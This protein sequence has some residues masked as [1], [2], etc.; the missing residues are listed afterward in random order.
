MSARLRPTVDVFLASFKRPDKLAAMIESVRESG[1]PARVL[2]AAGDL[3][4]VETCERYPGLVECVF[5]SA[6]NRRVG[7]TAP[8]NLVFRTLVRNDALFCTDDCVFA[9]D[10][11]DIA[12]STL[13]ERFP[14]TDGVV[15]LAQENIA[16][17]YDLAFPLMGRKFLDRFRQLPPE[18]TRGRA[19]SAAA[20]GAA[21]G[22]GLGQPGDLFWPGYFHLFN[23]AE[24]GLTIKCMG[25]WVFEPRA[26]L[27]HFHP[28]F[29][30]GEMDATHDHGLTFKNE[31]AIAWT[32][33]RREGKLWGADA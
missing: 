22:L 20:S 21:G 30:G 25:N 24:I 5:S 4:T 17:A 1:Y 9:P 19:H 14:D 13:H 33:R 29:G 6:V 10:A 32:T 27:R 12:M 28:E 31:D 3:G 8:L 16:G 11:L 23:D 7:C 15:G 2:V 26:K 18:F